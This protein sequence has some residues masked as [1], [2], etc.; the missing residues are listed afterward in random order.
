MRREGDSQKMIRDC[1]LA[2]QETIFVLQEW[3]GRLEQWQALGWADPADFA[4]ACCLLREAG[5]WAWADTI[6]GH[7][8]AALSLADIGEEEEEN[9]FLEWAED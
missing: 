2:T 7:G 5:L 3:A 4:D 9:G 8:I 6:A 1:L